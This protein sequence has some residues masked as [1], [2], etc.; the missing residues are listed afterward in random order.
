MA[1]EILRTANQLQ[2]QQPRVCNTLDSRTRRYRR[3]RSR[4]PRSKESSERRNIRQDV[5]PDILETSAGRLEN[6][7]TTPNSNAFGPTNGAAQR[8]KIDET[9]PSGGFIRLSNHEITRDA[10]SRISQ[11]L[12]THAPLNGFLKIFKSGQRKMPALR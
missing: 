1:T 7:I 12:L 10:A 9:T 5:P 6:I 8:T 11:L 2:K 4:R 3:K